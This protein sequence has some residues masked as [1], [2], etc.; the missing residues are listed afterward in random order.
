MPTKNKI[1]LYL[2][3]LFFNTQQSNL[4]ANGNYKLIFKI[5]IFYF[6]QEKT[7]SKKLFDIL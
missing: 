2:Y 4:Y 3:T 6:L 1:P 5:Q 7:L